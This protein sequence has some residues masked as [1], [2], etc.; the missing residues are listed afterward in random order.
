MSPSIASW[1]MAAMLL[2]LV[3]R[4]RSQAAKPLA[5]ITMRKFTGGFLFF[6][7]WLCGALLGS[8]SGYQSSAIH[9]FM[10]ESK[11]LARLELII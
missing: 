8:P 6:P 2:G 1:S 3:E 7:I 11:L 4:V 5:T 10:L 9:F